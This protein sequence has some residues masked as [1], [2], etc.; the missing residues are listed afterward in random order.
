LAVLAIAALLVAARLMP[1]RAADEP[2]LRA[3]AARVDIT[4][5]ES[6]P[7]ND[8]LYV[9]A[10]VLK[11]D[12][13]TA[14]VITVDA[15]SLGEIGYIGNEYLGKVRA[16]L[17]KDLGIDPARVVINASHCH[18][19]VCADVADRTVRAVKEAMQ[20]LE[21]VRVGAGVGHEDRIQENRRLRLKD[22][23]EAD[24]RHAY[25]LPPDDQVL[26][27]GPVDPEIGILRLDRKDGRPL[28]VV[29]NFACHP[30][31]GV[32]GGG[33]T[34]D[35]VGFASRVIEDGM[36]EGTTAL[37]LQGCAGDI[38]PA[39]YK[40]VTH[41]R[42]AEILGNMLGLST[43]R[44]AKRIKTGE[45]AALKMVRENLQLPRADFAPRIAAL[46]A[47]QGRLLKSLT[48]TSLNLKTFVQL[49]VNHGLSAEFPS[50]YS[51][52]YLRDKELGRDPFRRLDAE[53]RANVEAYLK[54]VQAME[55]LTKVQT[56]LSL[57]RMHAKQNADAGAK[58]LDVELVGLRVGEFVLT[59]FPG[60]LTAQIGLNLKQAS[61]HPLTF[62]AGYSNGYIYYSATTEQL[63]NT[64]AAQED[65]DTL[66][67]P[68]WQ[69][70]YERKAAELL[71][72]L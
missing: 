26:G 33:N 50:Y 9:K 68:E 11:D 31:Q 36:G 18:G 20:A 49:L 52:R 14:V 15:V 30:I 56:N 69:P 48:G 34:A 72:A 60:E 8:P 64:G 40:D 24:V 12:K 42:D 63:K 43:M 10:L 71:K 19:I 46:E 53:N 59:T 66:L 32:P 27:A 23:R 16:A 58:P 65:C 47:E 28:A 3:G 22:G 70:L 54:N 62:V 37:F 35:L 39:L 4:R 25:A 61:P 7:V 29:Y 67:A 55:E 44:A 41:P 57:L 51:H 5:T 13:T 45:K 6:G 38:N 21:P 2:S 17:Q 1:V